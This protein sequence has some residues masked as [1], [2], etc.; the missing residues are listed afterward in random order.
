MS[1][2]GI[3][4]PRRRT[5]APPPSHPGPAGTSGAPGSNHRVTGLRRGAE[6]ERSAIWTGTLRSPGIST[7]GLLLF[8]Q[9]GCR[10]RW[11]RLTREP[12]GYQGEPMTSI[13]RRW[14]AATRTI[15]VLTA[16]LLGLLALPA[17]VIAGPVTPAGA[18]SSAP[19]VYVSNDAGYVTP[20]DSS[21]NTPG[22]AVPVPLR[23]YAVA[24][25]PDG[26]TLYVAQDNTNTV[27][28][29]DTA[30]NTAGTPITVGNNPTGI[31]V[32]PDGKTAYV[33]NSSD[34]TVSA[35][36]VATHSVVATITVGGGPAHIA[37]T[38][39]DTTAYV[40]DGGTG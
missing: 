9:R 3:G 24:I 35:I 30:T 14:S 12:A 18:V 10:F 33:A 37:V 25:T 17:A 2:P 15:L 36:N 6:H 7:S 20:I 4:A 11:G 21:T 31:A 5:V 22:T 8:Q 32:T 29:I 27:T 40:T 13:L 34:G 23:P 26:K 28:P 19:T 16:C 38:P 39:D 1:N